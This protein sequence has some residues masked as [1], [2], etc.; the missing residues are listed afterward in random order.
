MRVFYFRF[1]SQRCAVRGKMAALFSCC[2]GCCGDGG[3]GHV[4]LK[5]MP[6]VQLD[7]HHMGT[8][9]VI[10]KSGRRICG[11]GGCLANAPLH[12][13]KSY[14]EFKIQSTGGYSLHQNKSYFEFKIQSTGV[15]G[16]GVA[17]Q[18]ANLNQIPMGRDVHSLV[19]RHDGSVY[20]NNEEKNRLPANSLPQEGDIVGITYDHVEMNLYL[21]GKNM[22]CPASGIRGTVLPVVYVDDSAILDCQFSDFYHTAPQGFE[23]ILFE[24][25]IF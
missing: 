8:D 5:E 18:K 15:W 23:K 19:L 4:P 12:Q 16:V 22:H 1:R 11:T 13:N 9:V 7:T 3:S 17:T 24:Q 14:F 10:V 25:Q 2:L 6:A 20:H 21:N